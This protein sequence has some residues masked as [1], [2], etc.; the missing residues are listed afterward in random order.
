[1]DRTK[2]LSTGS[3]IVLG[4][5]VLLFS[6]LFFTWQQNVQIDFGRAG[7]SM[8]ELDGWDFRGLLIGLMTLTV[9]AVVVGVHVTD[10]RVSEDIPWK[11]AVVALGGSIFALTLLKA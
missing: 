10:V 7:I 8:L 6:S 11:G 4:S 9:V 1:M 5:G 2:S 3:K